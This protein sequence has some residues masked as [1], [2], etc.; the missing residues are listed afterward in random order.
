[1]KTYVINLSSVVTT[2]IKEC[3]SAF[4]ELLRKYSIRFCPGCCFFTPW[5]DQLWLKYT[6][7]N[8]KDLIDDYNQGIIITEEFLGELLKIFGFQR[9]FSPLEKDKKNIIDSRND[10][11]STENRSDRWMGPQEIASALLE[12]AWKAM[13]VWGEESKKR[14]RTILQQAQEE[15]AEVVFMSNTNP[16]H[17][18]YFL[19]QTHEEFGFVSTDDVNVHATVYD[20]ACKQTPILVIGEHPHVSIALSYRFG[21]GKTGDPK[22]GQSI[23]SKL[24]ESYQGAE[25]I[26]LS[27]YDADL[28]E[29]ERL[30]LP[31]QK[32]DVF[33]AQC[34]KKEGEV[35]VL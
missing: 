4:E 2:D 25:I 23:L 9:E 27:Q 17:I 10:F 32:T 33:L 7:F 35:F 13:Q 28:Q 29:A 22:N 18:D 19:R 15:G 8:N 30:G 1:M 24:S 31:H 12:Q 6:F 20:E 14:L 21:L 34:D 3:F 5:T 11:Y 16:L 26:V